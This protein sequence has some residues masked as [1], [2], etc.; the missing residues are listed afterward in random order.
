MEKPEAITEKFHCTI[1]YR[2]IGGRSGKGDVRFTY[3]H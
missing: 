1:H 2:V 3:L